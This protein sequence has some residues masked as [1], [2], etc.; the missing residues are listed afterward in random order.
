MAA[1]FEVGKVYGYIK[2]DVNGGHF[3]P[4]GRVVRRNDA[5][6]RIT[7]ETVGGKKAVRTV[8]TGEFGEY[9]PMHRFDYDIAN[10]HAQFMEA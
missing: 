7:F 2:G 10:C 4:Y 3:V 6:G 1:R 9:V 8:I 5:T